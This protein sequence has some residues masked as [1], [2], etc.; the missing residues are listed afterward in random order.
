MLNKSKLCDIINQ[1]ALFCTGDEIM[2][3]NHENDIVYIEKILK[4]ISLIEETFGHFNITG[5]EEL[6]LSE[7]A[8][9]AVTQI[10]T[11]IYE[12]KKK[13]SGEALNNLTEF[14]KLRISGARNI[15]SHDYE[16]LNFHIIYSICEKLVSEKI[17]KEL[18]DGLEP[19]DTQ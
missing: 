10:I 3:K 14:N 12:S 8:E 7:I 11:N 19:G 16:N 5:A 9:L 1:R 2:E 4:Y 17:R 18:E 6:I 15:A 13:L